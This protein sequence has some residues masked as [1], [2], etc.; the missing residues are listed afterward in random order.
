MFV[1]AGAVGFAYLFLLNAGGL[2]AS[3][4]SFSVTFGGEGDDRGCQIIPARDGYMI[5]GNT[6]YG[7]DQAD[8]WDVWVM[9][10]DS[11]GRQVW[12]HTYGG[13]DD[14][15]VF[16]RAAV[17]TSDGGCLIA[18]S[19]RS[20][21]AGLYDGLVLKLNASG[22]KVWSRTFGGAEDDYLHSVD[23]TRDG[24]Y[25]VAGSV[26][27]F[28]AGSHD[29]WLIKLD[30]SGDK[31]WSRTYG[32]DDW[33]VVLTVRA[34]ADNGCVV[35]GYTGDNAWFF[36]VDASG[37]QGWSRTWALGSYSFVT[38]IEPTMD[39]GYYLAVRYRSGTADHWCGCV[40]KMDGEGREIWSHRLE[41]DGMY[42][43]N[44]VLATSDGGC[45]VCGWFKGD[46]EDT[47]TPW[48]LK[49]DARG[50]EDWRATY[51]IDG[52]VVWV[53]PLRGGRFM[54]AGYIRPNP[55]AKFDL[56]LATTDRQGRLEVSAGGGP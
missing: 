17:P 46:D 53:E 25:V 33:D 27:S 4:R 55:G 10:V 8:V 1:A 24:G 3:A 54:V 26:S 56:W 35:G 45:L 19:S 52:S 51:P 44:R 9:K 23:S 32:S 15:F 16:G 18:A 20:V 22:E 36:K 47:Q 42:A 11:S 43:L 41:G 28:G 12:A 50:R 5:V 48:L 7:S 38:S 21:G 40:Y 34:T 39:G 6:R 2:S 29:A 49:L 13:S 30:A 37:T 31:I 14:D